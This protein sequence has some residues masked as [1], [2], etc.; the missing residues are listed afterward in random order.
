MSNNQS[1]T[2]NTTEREIRTIIKDINKKVSFQDISLKINTILLSLMEIHRIFVSSFLVTPKIC[3]T[4]I[5][6]LQEMITSYRQTNYSHYILILNCITLII[7]I[8]LYIFEIKRETTLIH[9]LQND[10]S[11]SLTNK[12]IELMLKIMPTKALNKILHSNIQYK[13]MAIITIFFFICNTIANAYIL[14]TFYNYPSL[15]IFITN[16]LFMGTKL[17]NVY[18]IIHTD[19]Y[20]LYSAYIDD[21]YQFNDIVPGILENLQ[22]QLNHIDLREIELTNF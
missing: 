4:N 5:C 16:T 19:K 3:G 9:Y 15:I 20:I 13:R 6:N 18:T 7:F 11:M 2:S 22:I 8:F 10:K 21:K 14:Y 1:E 12:D 17:G